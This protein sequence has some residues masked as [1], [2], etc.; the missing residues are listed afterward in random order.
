MEKFVI[1]GG[2]RLSGSIYPSG[3]KNAILPIIAATLL[4]EEEV[5]LENVPAI[6]DVQ[7][8][9]EILASLGSNITR[10]SESSYCIHNNCIRQTSI[11]SD[12]AE[13]IRASILFAGPMV[14]RYGRMELFPP[15]GDVIG[16]RRLDTHIHVLGELG[17]FFEFN[18]SITM[19]A[20]KLIG[21]SIFLD[22]PS[23]TATENAIMAAVL[24]EGESVLR[25]VASEPHV[26]D[27]VFMLQKM[28]ANIEGNGSNVLKIRGVSKLNGCTHAV[29]N[30]HIEVGSFIGLAVTTGSELIIKNA[31]TE[32]MHSVDQGFVKLGIQTEIRGRD[33]FVP[34]NQEMNI[35]KDLF[36]AI[37]MIYDAP[38]P[39]F[40]A[41]LTS[42]AVVTA[43]QARGTIIVFEKMFESRLFFVDKL[44]AMGAQIVLCDPHRAV[45]AGPSQLRGAE[46]TS[47]DIR[48]G[49]AIL[50][51]SLCAKGRSV[52]HNINQIDRGYEKMEQRLLELGAKIERVSE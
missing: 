44:V 16:R 27:L 40:P 23:V 3:N 34:G 42:I 35:R 10:R 46:L 6:V 25:N 36:G 41:D 7:V 22:E 11:K 28:G 20:K 5:V 30:D 9:L 19:T 4:T 14:A 17:T 1:E 18:G 49:M 52:I 43:T 2:S 33:I 31:V 13:K 51:G 8:M 24:A 15:G 32:H 47:P 38:W 45:I 37:P 21:K 39:G 12:L 48:A 50:I 26:Q 29:V